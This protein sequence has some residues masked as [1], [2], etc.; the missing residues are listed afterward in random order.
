MYSDSVT[1]VVQENTGD[2]V[3]LSGHIL[4]ETGACYNALYMRFDE[5]QHGIELA[6]GIDPSVLVL[7]LDGW[8]GVPG[9]GTLVFSESLY[10]TWLGS[11]VGMRE[12]I[13]SVHTDFDYIVMYSPGGCAAID[14]LFVEESG[15]VMLP[16]PATARGG[17]IIKPTPAYWAPEKGAATDVILEP[18]TTVWALGPDESDA[19]FKIIF[20][21]H[22]LW[23][24]A[25]CL[26]PN[27]DE[28]WNSSP[29]P[30]DPVE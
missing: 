21:E 3:L 12:G 2:Y 26:A 23:V 11:P 24:P 1:W 27:P 17:L 28:V 13:A 19:F 15:G 4:Q 10:G 6:Y 30:V 7:K 9:P 5:I 8:I 20:A 22:Y 18:G 14:D 25:D 16:I 29:L